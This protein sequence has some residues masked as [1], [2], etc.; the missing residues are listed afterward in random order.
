MIYSNKSNIN[1][2]DYFLTLLL[3]FMC[4]NQAFRYYVTDYCYVIFAAISIVAIATGFL[5]NRISITDI[6]NFKWYIVGV[7]AVFFLQIM[8]FNYAPYGGIINYLSKTITG[9][10]IILIVGKKFRYTYFNLMYYISI[11]CLFMWGIQL[12]TGPN[13]GLLPCGEEYQTAIFFQTRERDIIRNCGFFWE[14][15]AY[16]CYLMIIPMLFINELELLV[17]NN[18]KKCL[19]LLIALLS[20]QSTT[21]YLVFALLVFG[22]LLRIKSNVK[23]FIIPVLVLSSL[24]AYNTID[25]LSEKINMQT[26]ESMEKEGDYSSHRLG[27][28]LFDLYYIEK[29][30]IVGNGLHPKT[31]WADH[32][33]IYELIQEGRLSHS[34]NGFSGLIKSMGLLF[35]LLYLYVFFKTNRNAATVD[36]ILFL[37][38]LF[39]ILQGEP[40]INYPLFMGLPFYI[41]N[42][43]FEEYEDSNFVNSI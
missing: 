12:F 17:K 6:R 21:T 42:R 1:R 26:E 35:L 2:F 41:I 3:L 24:Y 43:N 34:G 8:T 10:T 13:M 11:F 14:P 29:H 15:G 22:Y 9:I 28:L 38:V 32:Y 20:T 16:G 4:G 33:Y 25:F 5:K 18:K 19:I 40:L 31:L 36:K 27:S 23:F 7:C 37:L 30:P 39:L